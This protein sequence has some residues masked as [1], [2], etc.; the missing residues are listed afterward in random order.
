MVIDEPFVHNGKVVSPR[1]NDFVVE[2]MSGG[3]FQI[4]TDLNDI[5]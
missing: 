3:G 4:V 5:R 1:E 2:E